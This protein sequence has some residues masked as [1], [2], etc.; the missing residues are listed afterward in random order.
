MVDIDMDRHIYIMYLSLHHCIYMVCMYH[1]T[2][3]KH[4][5]E[6]RIIFRRFNR[7]VWL[8]IIEV[9]LLD[10]YCYRPNIVH[11]YTIYNSTKLIHLKC[12]VCI[13]TIYSFDSPW[14]AKWIERNSD[15]KGPVDQ[16]KWKAIIW[17]LRSWI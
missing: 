16:R 15:S 4:R 2:A 9:L 13:F 12:S 11:I 3:Y 8:K 10:Y 1:T 5:I 6:E 17:P 14:Q 7:F